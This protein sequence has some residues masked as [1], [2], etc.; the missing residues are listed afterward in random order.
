[1]KPDSSTLTH[2]YGSAEEIPDL[3]E[4]LRGEDRE[5]AGFRL[6]MSILHQGSVYSATVAALPLLADV[7]LD[8]RA[9]GRSE[10]LSLLRCSGHVAREGL[11]EVAQTLLPLADDPDPAVRLA[12]DGGALLDLGEIEPEEVADRLLPAVTDPGTAAVIPAAAPVLKRALAQDQGLRARARQALEPVP[13][14]DKRF[15]PTREDI[16][17][18]LCLVS[19]LEDDVV[20]EVRP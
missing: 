17:L 5:V 3:I 8:R 12:L 14:S 13:R 1:M 6:D 10:A 20:G 19:T 18:D 15:L 9:Q 2:A 16:G 11:A 7:A 4:E